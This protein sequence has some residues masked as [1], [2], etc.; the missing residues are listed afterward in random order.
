MEISFPPNW[1]APAKASIDPLVSWTEI[2]NDGIKYFSGT[3][4][5][6]LDLDAPQ[7]WFKPDAKIILDLGEVKEI[8]EVWVNGKP[9]G[10]ILWKPPYRADVTAALVPGK[11]HL[12]IKVTNLW[13]NRLIGDQQPNAKPY[14]WVDYR[15]FKDSTPLLESGLLGPVKVLSVTTH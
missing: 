14:A 9:V 8:A 5:Y 13:P 6:R 7:D 2:P 3:A 11:N 10:E 12:E 4:T 1:G 15:P